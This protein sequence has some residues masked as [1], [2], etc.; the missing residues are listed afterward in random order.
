MMNPKIKN[1]LQYLFFF[2]LGIFL[3]WWSLR[4]V[5][6]HDW[7]DIREAFSHTHYLLILPI[8]VTLLAS[9]LSRAIR[10]KI[11]IKP[12][13]VSPKLSNTFSAVLVGYLANLALPRLGEI[14][15]CTLLARYEKVPA[16]KLIGTIVAERAFDLVCLLLAISLAFL[17][18]SDRISSYLSLRAQQLFPSGATIP[19]TQL[20]LGFSL[21]LLILG[22][23][24][25][26]LWKKLTR[27]SWFHQML[28]L[29]KGIGQGLISVRYIQNKGWFLFHTL[30]IWSLYL[31]SVLLGIYA[32]DGTAHLGLKASLS[33]LST[34]SIA[35]ILTPSGIGA[36]PLFV[37]ETLDL[38]DITLGLGL[39]MG[40]MMWVVQFFLV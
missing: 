21:I 9:H 15:K 11:L 37:Q 33:V 31:F 3:V 24:L 2:G 25:F 38:Y 18:Q 8:C 6:P 5:K 7:Q 14:L 4:K 35:M 1:L 32:M 13:G 30:L 34:G 40:W 20:I 10:W 19:G 12:L 29:G 39:A 27:L 17:T 16:D 23:A 22:V 36:Y 26:F 28:T